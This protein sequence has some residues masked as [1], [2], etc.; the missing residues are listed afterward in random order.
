M[1]GIESTKFTYFLETDEEDGWHD[2]T[3]GVQP[4]DQIHVHPEED[5]MR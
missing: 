1:R 4:I 5:E 2:Q 3:L